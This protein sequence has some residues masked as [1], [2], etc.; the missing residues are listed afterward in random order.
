LVRRSL[1]ELLNKVWRDEEGV[2]QDGKVSWHVRE[3]REVNARR[4]RSESRARELEGDENEEPAEEERGEV[5]ASL[6]GRLK[7][8]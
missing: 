4:P 8:S 2:W 5:A 1:R 7:G 6:A 3:S